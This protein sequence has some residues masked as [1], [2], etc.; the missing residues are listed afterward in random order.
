M[1]APPVIIIIG[2]HAHHFASV[3]E[4]QEFLA[5]KADATVEQAE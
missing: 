3:A 2:P 1:S 5:S 4:A